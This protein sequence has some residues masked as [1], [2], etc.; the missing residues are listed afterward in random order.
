LACRSGLLKSFCSWCWWL[1][2][3][4]CSSNFNTKLLFMWLSRA[5]TSMLLHCQLDWL[6]YTK[7]NCPLF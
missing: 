7:Y 4:N 6:F 1:D 3:W 2:V 5:P